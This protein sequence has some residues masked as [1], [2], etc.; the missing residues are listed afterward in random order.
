M[1]ARSYKRYVLMRNERR[2][3]RRE[4][5]REDEKVSGENSLLIWKCSSILK[6]CP[7]L[8]TLQGSHVKAVTWS[9]YKSL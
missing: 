5:T 9:L 1:D 8:M 7:L 3:I 2:N 6:H 4:K